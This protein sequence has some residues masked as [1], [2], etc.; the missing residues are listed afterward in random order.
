M[1]SKEIK[2]ADVVARWRAG[3]TETNMSGFEEKG[4]VGWRSPVEKTM[5]S[6]G[7][8]WWRGLAVVEARRSITGVMALLEREGRRQNNKRK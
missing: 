7:S 1:E 2:E 6:E 4:D 5:L 8:R 3:A